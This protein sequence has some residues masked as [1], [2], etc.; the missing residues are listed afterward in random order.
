MSFTDV[1][2]FLRVLS[3]LKTVLMFFLI[4]ILAILSVVPWIKGRKAQELGGWESRWG[5]EKNV[6]LCKKLFGFGRRYS[7]CFE[8]HAL[9]GFAHDQDGFHLRFEGL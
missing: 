3:G 6:S 2:D 8:G 5:L 9:N 7:H 4:R 1:K